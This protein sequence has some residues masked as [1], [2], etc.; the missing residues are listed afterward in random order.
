MKKLL[1]KI[2]LI[3]VTGSAFHSTTIKS[4]FS[5]KNPTYKSI[6]VAVNACVERRNNYEL[7]SW[8]RFQSNEIFDLGYSII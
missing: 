7:L 1:N 4:I 3:F 6:N 8:I 5:E 2:K